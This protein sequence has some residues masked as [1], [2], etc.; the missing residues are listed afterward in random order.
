MCHTAAGSH[1]HAAFVCRYDDLQSAQEN[2]DLQST[3]LS[4]F[5]LIFI[6][7]DTRSI[8]TDKQ[9]ARHVYCSQSHLSCLPLF[10]KLSSMRCRH[11]LGV[12]RDAGGQQ[13]EDE[14]AKRVS[15]LHCRDAGGQQVC[16][17]LHGEACT[18]DQAGTQC[19]ALW[20]DLPVH[21]QEEAFFKRYLEYC[22]STCSPRLS[23]Q[24][25][26]FLVNE[27]VAMRG[28]VIRLLLKGQ[29]D[30]QCHQ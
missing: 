29:H 12:H 14:D 1:C 26:D 24:A 2:I 6:V 7:K 16:K 17:A 22:R 20:S 15:C 8:E 23:E 5:D 27:Y 9:I 10:W 4:R 13:G 28:K 3:I 21:V 30:T 11:V 18:G 25:G 19:G